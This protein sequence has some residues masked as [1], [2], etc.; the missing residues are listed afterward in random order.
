M[1]INEEIMNRIQKMETLVNEIKNK[2][3]FAYLEALYSLKCDYETI[4]DFDNACKYADLIIDLL[5][6]N[7]IVCV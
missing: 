3:T 6:H 4:E 5:S 7:K 2:T 1:D